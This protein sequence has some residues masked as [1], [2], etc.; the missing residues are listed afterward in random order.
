MTYTAS[1]LS[2]LFRD[3]SKPV[4]LTGAERPIAQL[5]TDA[6]ANIMNA[7]QLAAP[8]AVAKPVV[9]EVCIYFGGKLIRGNR[10]KKVHSLAFAGFDSPNCELLGTVED[11]IDIHTV[12][13]RPP[14]ADPYSQ[15]SRAP[16][17]LTV[18]ELDDQVA[19]FEIYPSTNPCLDLLEHM[20]TKSDQVRAVVL[21]TYGTGN[22][23]T[24]PERFLKII[25][26]GVKDHGRLIVNLTSCPAGQVEVRLFE[27][28]ARLF[29]LGVVNGGD[30][31]SEAAATKLMW[32]LARHARQNGEI[33]REAIIRD[34]QIDQRGEL[35]YSVYN[36]VEKD[37]RVEGD[38]YAPVSQYIGEIEPSHID[39]AYLRVHGIRIETTVPQEFELGLYFQSPRVTAATAER[40]VDH[41]IGTVRREWE[42]TEAQKHDGITFNLDATQVVRQHLQTGENL[43]VQMLPESVAPVKVETLELAIFTENR[44]RFA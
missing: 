10:A 43:S 19:I 1:A 8:Q 36:L 38:V 14:P 35:R 30:M 25:E 16:L 27:T 29:E 6:V 13:V 18:D 32:L 26:A 20:L 42:A 21:K 12:V 28:N 33:D 3:L 44:A 2:F 31:T 39:H 37:I 4:L 17:H 40:M 41:R 9:P 11:K 34:M 24:L 7:L 5:L 22:A 15:A 23:P